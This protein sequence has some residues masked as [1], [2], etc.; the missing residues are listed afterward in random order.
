MRPMKRVPAA[1]AVEGLV[2]PGE[3][4]LPWVRGTS[5]DLMGV[6]VGVDS[7]VRFVVSAEPTEAL[8]AAGLRE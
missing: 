6:L 7:P 3:H 1:D 2:G 5:H 4:D 8:E